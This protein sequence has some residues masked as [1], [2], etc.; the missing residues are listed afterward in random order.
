MSTSIPV[1]LGVLSRFLA[2][3]FHATRQGA[4]VFLAI[5]ALLTTAQPTVQSLMIGALCVGLGEM[6]RIV[7][8]G[9]GYTVGEISRRGPYRFVR[10]PYFLGTALVMIGLAA[11]GRN[12][13]V[14]TLTLTGMAL[15][16][17]EDIRIDER[18]YQRVFGPS[19]DLYRAQVPALIPRLWGIE[20][21]PG[22]QRNFSL[23]WAIFKGRHRE[24]D[25]V[26]GLLAAFAALFA[27]KE[28]TNPAFLHAG[29]FVLGV[30]LVLSRMIYVAVRPPVRMYKTIVSTQGD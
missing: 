30:L 18:R 15:V 3:R 9:Y 14:V 19:Y 16:L 20:K 8:A 13:W 29:A 25:A 26:L 11:A 4:F 28:V 24:L 21:E 7:T 27:M 23:E 2:R 17:R 6:L 22:D 5:G 10:H 12:A 1:P